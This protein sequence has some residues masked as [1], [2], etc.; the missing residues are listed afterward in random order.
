MNRIDKKF[1]ELKAKNKTAFIPF[2]T[3]GDPD[4]QTTKAP[5]RKLFAKQ[6]YL[7]TLN[8]VSKFFSNLK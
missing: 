6:C 7:Q 2:I 4:L 1:Q 8:L 5:P 3:A